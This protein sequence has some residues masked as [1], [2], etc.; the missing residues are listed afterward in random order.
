M[1]T[2]ITLHGYVLE[3]MLYFAADPRNSIVHSVLA[4]VLCEV[5]P[6]PVRLVATDT[7]VLGVLHLTAMSGYGLDIACDEPT[8]LVLPVR[9]FATLLKDRRY[10]TI[11]LTIEGLQVTVRNSSGIT[12]IVQGRPAEEYP[13]YS[14]V[15]PTDS[16]RPL[17]GYAVDAG[18]MSKI[19]A[20]CKGLK[21]EPQIAL[22]FTHQYGPMRFRIR[23][24]SSFL[25]VLM[26]MGIE[27]TA[28]LPDW[29]PV[30]VEEPR[31]IHL[32]SIDGQA[33]L[34]GIDDH[35]GVWTSFTVDPLAG[36]EPG[37]CAI[38]GE[39]MLTGWQCLEGGEEVCNAHVTVPVTDVSNAPV[40]FST[41][42]EAIKAIPA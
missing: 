3:A 10:P 22:G 25:G 28:D 33:T 4:D 14:R 36:Q 20:F 23:H 2:T 15:I 6:E 29:Y 19:A 39:A 8:A 35:G 17:A 31:V 40:V 18:L 7:H 32:Q 24:L 38:C 34:T 1:S 16:A 42:A 27:L 30:P 5:T 21:I 37:T 11:T 13:T 41:D 26:P 12:A 9:E